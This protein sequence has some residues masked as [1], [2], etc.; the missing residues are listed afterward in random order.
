MKKEEDKILVGILAVLILL[1]LIQTIFSYLNTSNTFYIP[2]ITG[3]L[4]SFIGILFELTGYYNKSIYVLLVAVIL[5]IMW[6]LSIFYFKFSGITF[7]AS[8]VFITLV[9]IL[10]LPF[11]L[12]KWK[13][14]L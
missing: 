9:I 11:V 13:Q 4:I 5:A 3:F 8:I 2:I 7:Y 6:I 14:P 1:I 12:K 10:S